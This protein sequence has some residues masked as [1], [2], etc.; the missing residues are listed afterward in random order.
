MPPIP[1]TRVLPPS[2]Y[3]N[4]PQIGTASEQMPMETV[5]A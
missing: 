3:G 4:L 2:H 5:V 1:F